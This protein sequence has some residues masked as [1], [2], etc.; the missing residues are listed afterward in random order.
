MS[1]S[2]PNPVHTFHPTRDELLVLARDYNDNEGILI[3]ERLARLM[4]KHF[5]EFETI[6]S[7]RTVKSVL[8]KFTDELEHQLKCHSSFEDSRNYLSPVM[9]ELRIM[10]DSAMEIRSAWCKLEDFCYF[11]FDELAKLVLGEMRVRKF[12]LARSH[13]DDDGSNLNDSWTIDT[14]HSVILRDLNRQ[15]HCIASLVE[16]GEI[17]LDSY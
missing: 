5:S 6:N 16:H 7:A 9:E 17:V 4:D 11:E 10:K 2:K 1:Q 12:F 3:I 15:G 8:R 14:P 13:A